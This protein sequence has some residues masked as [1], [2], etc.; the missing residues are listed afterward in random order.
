MD[1]ARSRSQSKSTSAQET[2]VRKSSTTARSFKIAPSSQ[3]L[4][5][6]TLCRFR[7]R[8]R[9][10]EARLT[11]Q[12]SRSFRKGLCGHHG[13]TSGCPSTGRSRVAGEPNRGS[14]EANTCHAASTA[15]MNLVSCPTMLAEPDTYSR[16]RLFHGGNEGSNFGGTSMFT[17]P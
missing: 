14:S 15:W 9:C 3:R 4:T 17:S 16:L 12:R 6:E 5:S 11:E 10:C 8:R 1:R 2:K 7:T 13:I